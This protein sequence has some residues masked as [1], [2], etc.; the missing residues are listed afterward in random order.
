M[1]SFDCAEYAASRLVPLRVIAQRNLRVAASYH[2]DEAGQ[3][4]QS[5]VRGVKY[6]YPY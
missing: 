6:E 3:F 5:P 2:R 1:S 4:Y